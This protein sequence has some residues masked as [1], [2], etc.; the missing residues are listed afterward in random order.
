MQLLKKRRIRSVLTAM[1]AMVLFI[2]VCPLSVS[3]T[4]GAADTVGV[5]VVV[6]DPGHGGENNGDES[7][8]TFEKYRTM[9]T[10]LAMYEELSKYE[11]VQVYLTRTE[12]VDMSLKERAEFAASVNADMLC[13]IHYNASLEHEIFGAEL[14]IPSEAPLNAPMYQFGR[15][16]IEQMRGMGLHLRGI[17]SRVGQK[18]DYY[19]VIRESAALGIPAVILEH[20]HLDVA[21]DLTFAD[22]EEKMRAF[23]V[24]DATA[25]AQYYGLKS[26]VLGVDYSATQLVQV[27]PYDVVIFPLNVSTVPEQCELSIVS[28]NEETG[29]VTFKLEAEDSEEALQYYDYSLD[30]GATFWN[31]SV[32]PGYELYKTQNTGSVTFSV[33]LPREVDTQFVARVYNGYD[34]KTESERLTIHFAYQDEMRAAALQWEQEHDV[35][36]ADLQ[37]P[38]GKS[39]VE[40]LTLQASEGVQLETVGSAAQNTEVQAMAGEAVP[41]A[42]QAGITPRTILAVISAALALTLVIMGASLYKKN[43]AKR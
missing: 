17:K 40:E 24:A 33:V 16:W 12:D 29:E 4:S 10:A 1:I 41:G 32:W 26:T 34:Q 25:V 13:S 35:A 18:G 20:C 9:V 19:G 43:R 36:G 31:L 5:R 8:A 30:G 42:E 28:Q 38:A 15:L 3:A 37:A 7:T 22:T 27:N 11:G 21:S 23:G 6:I 2:A 39:G 14:W